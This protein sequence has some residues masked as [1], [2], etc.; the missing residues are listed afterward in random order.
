MSRAD[1]VSWQRVVA[2]VLANIYI[3]VGIAVLQQIAD[4]R[5]FVPS[6]AINATY[7]AA[8]ILI[9][10]IVHEAGHRIVGAALGWRCV[11]FGFGPFEFYREGKGW[12][13]Q[14]VKML[15]GAFVR[16]APASF[17]QFRLHKAMTLLGGPM[18]SL[19]FGL[20]F[21]GIALATSNAVV[22]AIFGDMSLLTFT[23]VLELIP[24]LTKSGIGSDGQ[25]LA[26]VIRGGET[27]D[28]LQW[29]ILAEASNFT[30]LRHRDWP[31]DMLTR[32][33]EGGDPYLVYLAYLHSMDAGDEEAAA[34]YMRRLITGL[35][36]EKPSPYYACEAAY[37]LAIY[38]NDARE[39]RKWMERIGPGVDPETR[40]RAEAA[41]AFT[42]GQA[43]RAESLAKEALALIGAPPLS[44]SS[45]YAV[46]RL[47]RLLS[48][49]ECQRAALMP[50]DSIALRYCEP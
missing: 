24:R 43:E 10:I 4:A 1:C 21:I 19:V 45:E 15:W 7:L 41:V 9:S 13:T 14:R 50:T 46:D 42:E 23:G 18:S 25:R 3:L 40:L 11:R 36:E 5:G 26:Q 27:M 48:T 38:G 44:G 16:Q 47:R 20:V 32:L 8:G 2:I 17:T 39:A 33:A 12:K 31:H 34:G 35:P 6:H 30:P 37:W 29:P 28:E 22:F 49:L